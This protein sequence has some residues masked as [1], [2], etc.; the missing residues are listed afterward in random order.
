M[1]HRQP[2]GKTHAR[3]AR[4]T[5]PGSGGAEM[6]NAALAGCL[7]DRPGRNKINNDK[8]KEPDYAKTKNQ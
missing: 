3:P 5:G 2:R 8:P 1:G 4:K 6:M 7:C